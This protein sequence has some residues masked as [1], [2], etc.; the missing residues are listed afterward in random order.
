MESDGSLYYLANFDELTGIPNRHRLLEH[1]EMMILRAKRD[2][3]KF[4]IFFIDLDNLKILNDFHGHAAGDYVLNEICIRIGNRVRQHEMLARL[5]GDEFV[6]VSNIHSG[7]KSGEEICQELEITPSNFW[8][9]V[10]RAKLQLR[11]CI[12]NNWFKN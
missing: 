3:T 4:T 12:E 6:L 9:I 2:K 8:Q 10:H 5:D 1:I 7:Q 11:D